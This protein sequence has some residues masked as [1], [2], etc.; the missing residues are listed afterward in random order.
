MSTRLQLSIQLIKEATESL[1]QKMQ[2]LKKTQRDVAREADKK[3]SEEKIK[4]IRQ[5]L[6]I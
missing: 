6:G 4:T 3:E 1:R 5:K 2:V